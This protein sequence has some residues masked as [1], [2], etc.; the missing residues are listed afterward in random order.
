MAGAGWYNLNTARADSI[1]VDTW[2]K[3]N[4]EVQRLY[5]AYLEDRYLH[6]RY[7]KKLRAG[8]GRLE[9]EVR[10]RPAAVRESPTPED[11]SSGDALN[12]LAGDLADPTIAPTSWRSAS[13]PLPP[14][15]SLT[16]LAF[17]IADR[18]VSSVMQTTVAIDR[19]LIGE[20]WPLWLRRPELKNEEIAY[21]KA[22]SMVVEKC[23]KGTP[24]EAKD[25]DKLRETVVALEKKVPEVVPGRDNQREGAGI[26]QAAGRGHADLRRAD[27][28]GTTYP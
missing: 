14:E 5:R 18:K 10:G 24:L 2:K 22:V 19:L 7:K 26:R 11:I 17:K 4:L 16:S 23:R 27:V 1:N 21:E 3:H 9:E 6:I 8:A 28:R 25:V 13:V 12:A 20:G 15:L